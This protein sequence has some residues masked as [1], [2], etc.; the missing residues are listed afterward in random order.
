[1]LETLITSKT[2]LKLIL[3]LF[4]NPESSSYLRGL[5][6]E[7]G[8]SSNAIRVELNRFE[9]AGLLLSQ[10]SGNKKM[11]RANTKHPLY[12]EIHSIVK[13]TFGIDKIVNDVIERLGDVQ[14]AYII[15]DFAIGVNG[16]SIDIV[17]VGEHIKMDFLVSLITKVEKMIKKKIRYMVL[18]PYEASDFLIR[19]QP[20][21]LFW[22]SK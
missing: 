15:G 13:K 19:K 21:M 8:E 5:A 20:N 22:K 4:L 11:Y 17:L 10:S 16:P 1:M 9:S 3:K 2:R 12:D 18:Q 6:E 14:E 7:F